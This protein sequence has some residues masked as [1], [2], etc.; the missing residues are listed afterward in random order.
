MSYRRHLHISG[1]PAFYSMFYCILFILLCSCGRNSTQPEQALS[2]CDSGTTTSHTNAQRYG[3]YFGV[4]DLEAAGEYEAQLESFNTSFGTYPAYVLW[5]QQIDDTL[6]I[7]FISYCNDRSIRVV[8]SLNIKS[9]SLSAARNDTLL[10]EIA[11]GTWDNTIHVLARQ[12]KLAD[13]PLYMR[14]GYEMN[15]TWFCWGRKKQAFIAAWNHAHAV[16]MQDSAFNVS[17]VFAPG[18]LWRGTDVQSDL[19]AY[20]PGDSVVDIVG[21]DGYNYGDIVKDGYQLHWTSF[22]DVF[23]TS[24]LAIKTLGKPVWITEAGC[25]T[26]SRRSAWLIDVYNFMDDNPCVDAFL[27]FNAHK[28]G[29]PDFRIESDSASLQ[30]A[31]AWLAR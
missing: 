19:L 16:F 29:E 22:N 31:K 23:K 1:S 3:G 28:T 26:D 14:F 25:P 20:Y 10:K 30:A 6:P 24:L 8:I 4:G 21:L 5:F 12:A 9:L 17:W 18:A 2:L 27:W 11:A 13:V 15:G 7:S